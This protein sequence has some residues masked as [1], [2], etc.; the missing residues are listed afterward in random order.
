MEV[1]VLPDAAA[2]ARTAADVVQDLVAR[3]PAAVLGLATGS[4]V[5]PL[6][7]ELGAR[8][9]A[10]TFSLREAGGFLLDEYV[11]LPAGHPQAYRQV[12]A[13]ELLS[14]VDLDPG[15]VHGPEAELDDVDAACAAYERAIRD[16]GGIDLQLLGIGSDGHLAFN[17]PGSSLSSRTRIKTLTERTRGDNARFFD[18][19]QQVP[20]HVLTQGLGTILEARHLLLLATGERKAEAVAAMVEGPLAARCPASVLQLHRYATVLVDPAA[21]SGLELVDYYREVAA[22]KPSWQRSGPP[23][24]LC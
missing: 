11:G 7:E 1:L 12:I 15:S 16:A 4:S 6:Y 13:T 14:R 20:R 21:A 8:V 22:G 9:A 19:A 23:P 3:K 18:D 10:G 24:P 2:V 17:E 5:L